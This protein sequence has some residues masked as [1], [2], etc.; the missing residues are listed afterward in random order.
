MEKLF[1]HSDIYKF[2]WCL[3]QY[4]QNWEK[5]LSLLFVNNFEFLNYG[6]FA[7]YPSLKSS[8]VVVII[9]F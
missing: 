5:N 3:T 8:L 7:N 2:M 4:N 1:P 6:F 9:I